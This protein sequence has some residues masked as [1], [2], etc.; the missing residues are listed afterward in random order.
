MSKF[1]VT[2][3][4]E[5]VWKYVVEIEATD[6]EKAE[7]IVNSMTV[8]DIKETCLYDHG[9][10]GSFSITYVELSEEG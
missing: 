5:E 9:G 10:D 1:L 8:S 7:E 6:E 2:V 3:E 4:T